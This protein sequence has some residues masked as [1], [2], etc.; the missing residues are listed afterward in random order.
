LR[1][2]GERNRTFRN[3]TGQD[4]RRKYYPSHVPLLSAAG[5]R[6]IEYI[7]SGART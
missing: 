1:A 5:L 7:G 2:I 3:A 6:S 4:Y